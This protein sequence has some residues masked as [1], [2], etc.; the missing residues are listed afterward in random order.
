M[1]SSSREPQ[2]SLASSLPSR[3]LMMTPAL[4]A[5]V[6]EAVAARGCVGAV[7][8]AVGTAALA[9]LGNA[10]DSMSV[11]GL[12]AIRVLVKPGHK[13][14]TT[15]PKAPMRPTFPQAGR[16]APAAGISTERG[17]SPRGIARMSLAQRSKPGPKLAEK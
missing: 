9:A 15:N 4:T 10:D 2:L 5:T 17:V 13:I 14:P 16:S 12:V 3:H 8:G 7:A 1:G 11:C 6:S